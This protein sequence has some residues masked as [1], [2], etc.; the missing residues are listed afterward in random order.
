MKSN[1]DKLEELVPKMYAP[2]YNDPFKV[3][4]DDLE[5][6]TRALNVVLEGMEQVNDDLEQLVA[7]LDPD[8]CDLCRKPFTARCNN[9]DCSWNTL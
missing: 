6:M 8:V 3:I 2:K 1:T 4:I 5:A 7:E 9:G